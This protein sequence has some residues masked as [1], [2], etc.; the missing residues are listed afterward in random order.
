MDVST[1]QA[2]GSGWVIEPRREGLVARL[3]EVWRYR[4]LLLFFAKKSFTKFSSRTI[5]GGWWL[6]IRPLAPL[7][8]S[9]LVFGSVL[10]VGS[11]GVPY[12]L[13]VAVGSA[14]W[15][16]FAQATTWGTRSL[17][18]NRNFLT[19]IYIPRLILPISN[20]SPAILN[21]AIHI[22]I[23]LGAGVYY[24]YKTGTFY[25]TP[26]GI[27]WAAAAVVM[28]LTL[29]LGIALW[30]SVPAMVARDV[31]FTLMYVMG[32]WQFL[33]PVLYPLPRTGKYGWLLIFNPMAAVVSMF[34]H[35]VLGLEAVNF[36]DIGA[37]LLVIGVVLSSGL[38]FFGRA[39]GTAADKA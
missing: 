30:T 11:D 17:E 31:R 16:L 29:A 5:L 15:D 2:L 18:M 39:E 26:L 34:K 14:T 37:A 3:R 23:I 33:T 8:V 22:A 19:R 24:W 27:G 20:M 4:R 38:W 6:V 12:F 28:S 9:T 35:G 10:N 25:L 36:T 32:F 7:L 21:F 13:F 1:D